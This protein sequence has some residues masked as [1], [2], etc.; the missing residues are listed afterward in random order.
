MIDSELPWATNRTVLM[1]EEM[2]VR[3]TPVDDTNDS[4]ESD[5]E[6]PEE[7]TDVSEEPGILSGNKEEPRTTVIFKTPGVKTKGK[8]SPIEEMK[9]NGLSSGDWERHQTLALDEEKYVSA[10]ACSISE[11]NESAYINAVNELGYCD[12]YSK[13]GVVMRTPT[14]LAERY[15]LLYV[16]SCGVCQC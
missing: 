5:L 2:V 11:E 13:S 6:W 10:R 1:K 16:Q 14:T 4:G 15:M 7:R 8:E 9:R 12:H 3:R